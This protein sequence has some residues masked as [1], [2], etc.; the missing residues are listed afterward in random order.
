[1]LSRTT[2]LELW[3][4]MWFVNFPNRILSQY[5]IRANIFNWP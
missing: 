2:R 5:H 3:P 4:Q 1:L